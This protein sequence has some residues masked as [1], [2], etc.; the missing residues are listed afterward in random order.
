MTVFS[1][2]KLFKILHILTKTHIKTL[3]KKVDLSFFQIIISHVSKNHYVTQF[4]L[5]DAI[6]NLMGEKKTK[7]ELL[8]LINEEFIE[9]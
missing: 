1:S 7:P 4:E 2:K 5:I 3:T 9:S 8:A 6:G